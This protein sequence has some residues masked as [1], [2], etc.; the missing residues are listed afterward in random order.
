MCGIFGYTTTKPGAIREGALSQA[1]R[2]L[3]HRGP[4]DEGEILLT[5]GD[6]A[7]GL[8]HR[9]LSIIDLS[10]AGHQPMSTEDGRF[11]LTYNGEVYNYADVR[12]E[13][14]ALGDRFRSTSDTE[15]VL[16]AYA[17]W[18]RDSLRRLRGMF[19]FGIF[20]AEHR[21]LVLARDR[22]G[23]K[24]LYYVT[25]DGGVT[26][27]SEIR[28]LLAAGAAPRKLSPW[29]VETFLAYGSVSEP[30][31]ILDR[32]RSLP[33]GCLL[34]HKG[35]ATTLTRYWDVPPITSEARRADARAAQKMSFQEAAERIQP[36]LKDAVRVMLV[37]DVPVG[38]FLSGGIDSSVIVALA[39]EASSSPVHTF[40]VTFDEG[41]YSEAPFAA[42]VARRFGCDH[43]QVHLPASR[44]VRDITA[45]VAA[46]DQPS[47]DGVN[48]YFVSKAAKEAGLRVA[49]SGLGADELFAGYSHFRTFDRMLTAARAARAASPLVAGARL[50]LYAAADAVGAVPHRARK[51]LDALATRG[52]PE[53]MY[54]VIRSMFT[55]GQRRALLD[56]DFVSEV[57]R[58]GVCVPETFDS[59]APGAI[60]AVNVL[61]ALEISNYLKN[62]LLRDT[63]V[64]SMAHALEVRPPFLDHLLVEELL[65]VPGRLK[66]RAGQSKP[67]LLASVPGRL[68]A[69]VSRPKMGFTLP[70]DAWFRGPLR[71]FMEGV[72]LGAPIRRLSF[73]RPRAVRALWS[74]FLRSPGLVSHARVW[75]IAALALWCEANGVD[76]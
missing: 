16:R 6:V 58:A 57:M 65:R 32:V 22:L 71:G 41:E 72:L 8:A 50:A 25:H 5:A 53:A 23:I 12:R 34:E 38:V 69:A 43:H 14:E 35:G 18:G 60:D 9:R 56:P 42:E 29:A 15:V 1:R 20:D 48:T 33:P 63:D 67:L 36:T 4:D 37:A 68:P 52:D 51:I 10:P 30:A 21:S 19:A 47:A 39:A 44:V 62:T 59:G 40:T 27:A 11:T 75:S 2:A 7:C 54:A 66:L 61:S 13:L 74:G 26:F 73:L 49:L 70:F 76:A 24:P 64:M 17:R 28:A 46:L 55:E 45:A 31:T 3:A